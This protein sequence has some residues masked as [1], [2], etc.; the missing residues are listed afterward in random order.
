MNPSMAGIVGSY[1]G[2]CEALSDKIQF[3]VV[4]LDKYQDQERFKKEMLSVRQYLIELIERNEQT[5]KQL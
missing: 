2:M 4:M 3:E 1:K 5:W